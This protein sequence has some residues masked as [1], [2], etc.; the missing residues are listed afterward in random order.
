MRKRKRRE[1]REREKKKE[2]EREVRGERREAGAGMDACLSASVS[3]S[4][5]LPTC[6]ANVFSL[7][8]FIVVDAN[9]PMVR[10]C[11]LNCRTTPLH[12]HPKRSCEDVY[13]QC[14]SSIKDGQKSS[15]GTVR[16]H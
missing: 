10:A 7:F 6:S 14:Y 1:R 16:M 13:V 4:I 15:F 9:K 5:C 12:T 8:F 3:A 2:R 11:E